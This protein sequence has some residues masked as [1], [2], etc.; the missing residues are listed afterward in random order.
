MTTREDVAR[1]AQK[2]IP[3]KRLLMVSRSFV[4]TALQKESKAP[5]YMQSLTS[6]EASGL[7]LGMGRKTGSSTFSPGFLMLPTAS[8]SFLI[9]VFLALIMV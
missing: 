4:D 1:E 9:M 6:R 7:L 8:L 2:N 3:P 5:F